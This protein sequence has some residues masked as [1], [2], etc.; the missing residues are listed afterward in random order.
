MITVACK[1]CNRFDKKNTHFFAFLEHTCFE[2]TIPSL[3][4]VEPSYVDVQVQVQINETVESS[5]NQDPILI[6]PNK[7]TVL[8]QTD[9]QIYKPGDVIKIRLL[10]LNKE[11]LADSTYKVK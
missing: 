6:Y 2:I 4:H 1:T 8:L 5:Q 11:L 3:K 9:R 7:I 10:A